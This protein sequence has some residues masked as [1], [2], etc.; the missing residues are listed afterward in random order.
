MKI[1]DQVQNYLNERK[2][3]KKRLSATAL[4]SLLITFAVVASLISPA[5]SMTLEQYMISLAGSGTMSTGSSMILGDSGTTKFPECVID[6]AYTSVPSGA[7]DLT[8]DITSADIVDVQGSGDERTVKFSIGYKFSA[9]HNVGVSSSDKTTLLYY[10]LP[11][12]IKIREAECGVTKILTDK[13]SDWR[14]SKYNSLGNGN[15]LIGY[16]SISTS[17][18]IVIQLTPDYAKYV[19]NSDDIKGWLEFT[20]TV[21][22]ADTAEGDQDVTLGGTTLPT[23]PFDDKNVTASKNANLQ[24]NTD[25]TATITWSIIVNNPG[26]Y[27]DLYGGNVTDAMFEGC[28]DFSTNPAN[29]GTLSG[30]TFTFNQ[31]ADNYETITLT[32]KTTVNMNAGNQKNNATLTYNQG[33]TIPLSK[34]VPLDPNAIK[35]RIT[36]SGEPSYKVTNDAEYGYVEWTVEAYRDYGISIKDYQV[37]DAA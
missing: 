14:D 24:I 15:A 3:K 34:D 6:T 33:Q 25:G 22:R 36:K 30:N 10:Q 13:S 16:Y 9:G 32:Y 31:D 5:V 29:V 7:Y 12:N 4:L 28:T 8:N 19:E 26:M 37:T 27:G 35:G 21:E 20:G 18:L 23:I 17:G 2:N 1:N 11:D